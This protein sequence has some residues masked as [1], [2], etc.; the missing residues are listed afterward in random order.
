M[1]ETIQG[2][3]IYSKHDITA[4][5]N[6]YDIE[7][8]NEIYKLTL[9]LPWDDIYGQLEGR[10]IRLD[11]YLDEKTKEILKPSNIWIQLIRYPKN[12]H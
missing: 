12:I 5:V 9:K 8:N 6:E 1:S 4:G 10:K 3:I 11:G 2:I 7:I